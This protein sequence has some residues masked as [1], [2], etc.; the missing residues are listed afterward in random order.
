MRQLVGDDALELSA[1]E[2]VEE[3]P[4]HRDRGV[5]RIASGGEGVRGRVLDHEDL[6]RGDAETDRERLDDIAQLWLLRR[7]ELAGLALREDQ[8]VPREVR[9]ERAADGERERNGER[10]ETA[11]RREILSDEV[12]KYGDERREER[13]EQ[14]SAPA[15]CRGRF[16][17]R[18]PR[19]R[20]V[21]RC[22]EG[23]G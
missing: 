5:L 7:A 13:D 1:V 17:N 8:L 22:H 19:R 4:R 9:R 23:K 12:A 6:G 10:G 11:T 18:D 2:L 15:V 21:R 3:P 20:R 16:V 14:D